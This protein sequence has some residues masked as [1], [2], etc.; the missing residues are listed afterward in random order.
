MLVNPP[1]M[2][3]VV[4]SVNATAIGNM[5]SINLG[6]YATIPQGAGTGLVQVTMRRRLRNRE[7]P[8]ALPAASSQH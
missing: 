5:A 4:A 2:K 8:C 1:T 7:E 6:T 3:G